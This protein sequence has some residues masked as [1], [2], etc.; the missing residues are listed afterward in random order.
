MII[1]DVGLIEKNSK[2]NNCP[3]NKKKA[4]HFSFNYD[5]TSAIATHSDASDQIDMMGI[6]PF[7]TEDKDEDDDESPF[8]V[9]CI[10]SF[11]VTSSKN[12]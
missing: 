3:S 2:D 4:V 8:L 6:L 9:V 5:L 12:A 1:N 7:P 10:D 11:F